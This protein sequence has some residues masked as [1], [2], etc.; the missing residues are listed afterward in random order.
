MRKRVYLAGPITGVE[1]YERA[2][3]AAA[4]RLRMSGFLPVSPTVVSK[5]RASLCRRPD[6]SDWQ[7]WMRATMFLLVECDGVAL[8]PGWRE[9]RGAMIEA[10]W[11]EAMGLP[12]REL[13]DWL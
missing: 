7:M 4:L 5:L 3:K 2:F 8:L 13:E 1:G 12:V 9:S 10:D 6:D 11:A